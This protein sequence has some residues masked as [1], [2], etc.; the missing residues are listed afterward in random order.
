MYR[1]GWFHKSSVQ[2][3][4]PVLI[5][6]FTRS[7]IRDIRHLLAEG[8]LLCRSSLPTDVLSRVLQLAEIRDHADQMRDM[9]QK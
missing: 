2:I 8:F 7:L 4:S 1:Y 6:R 9:L 3:H 5:P